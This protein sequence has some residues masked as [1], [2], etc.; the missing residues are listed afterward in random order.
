MAAVIHDDFWAAAQ[1][2]P[3]KQRPGFIYA[4]CAYSFEGQEPVGNPAWL[5]TFLVVKE[6]LN[7]SAERSEKAR[8]KA[9]AR[10]DKRDAAASGQ[11]DAE[12]HA[13]HMQQHMHSTCT[14]DAAASQTV[15]A[16]K[17]K[18]K[19]KENKPLIPF[20]EIIGHLNEKTGKG[21]KDSTPK[22]RRLIESRWA[23]GFTLEDFKAVI[24]VKSGDWAGTEMERYLRP[25]TL[26]GPKFE[27]YLNER[28]KEAPN[29]YDD[30]F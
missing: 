10:W 18:E 13:Q 1:A 11:D 28:G 5:P 27:G 16:E 19:E 2:M 21:Y 24:D 14:A 30:L 23:E 4:L 22:T 3:A 15:D 25:E 17:E 9:R 8:R 7:M 12:A 26:F 6:R 29:A 20:A